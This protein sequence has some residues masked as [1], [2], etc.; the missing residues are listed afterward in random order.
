IG[1]P[2]RGHEKEV[3][4]VAFSPDGKWII[5]ASNDSTVR[6]WDIDGNPIGQ[7]W[8]GHEK[9]VNSVAFSPDGKW[10]ISAS[11]DSTVR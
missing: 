1:Q 5:S 11:N 4:S 8:R 7:P 6:L 3:N 2:W 9:E 10:I